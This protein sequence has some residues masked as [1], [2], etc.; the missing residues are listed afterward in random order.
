MVDDLVGALHLA[1]GMGQVLNR[2]V[3]NIDPD[4]EPI[5]RHSFRMLKL[6]THSWEVIKAG[7][8][9]NDVLDARKGLPLSQACLR[10]NLVAILHAVEV[11]FLIVLLN[12][13]GDDALGVEFLGDRKLLSL[14]LRLRQVLAD[15]L[16][17][18]GSAVAENILFLFL[19]CGEVKAELVKASSRISELIFLLD[20]SHDDWRWLGFHW[21]AS[22]AG[23]KG[24]MLREVVRIVQNLSNV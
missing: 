9:I 23:P 19:N 21:F 8:F 14:E 17:I 11:N 24:D 5:K 12:L 1:D 10:S 15:R 2:L 7:G 16:V 20:L 18:D 3:V 4:W 13:V 22:L 6:F